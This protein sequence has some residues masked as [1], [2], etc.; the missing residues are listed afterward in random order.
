[1]PLIPGLIAH[2]RHYKAAREDLQNEAKRKERS[3]PL[4]FGPAFNLDD[5]NLI[6]E[7]MKMFSVDLPPLPDMPQMPGM[8]PGQRL[9]KPP[10]AGGG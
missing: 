7:T 2:V 3:A 1:M 9:Y 5:A 10:K 4:D 6:G 8:K